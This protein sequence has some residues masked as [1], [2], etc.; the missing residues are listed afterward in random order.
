MYYLKKLMEVSSSHS[1]NLNYE[2]PCSNKHGHNFKITVYCKSET[3]N[4]DGMIIDFTE[5]KKIVNNLMDH[6]DLNDV[7]TELYD[8][9]ITDELNP[10]AENLSKILHDTIPYCY[11]VTVQETDGNEVTYCGE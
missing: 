9:D 6:K 3:L 11:K 7:V 2:S 4:K 5:I 1:L 8:N 10:T